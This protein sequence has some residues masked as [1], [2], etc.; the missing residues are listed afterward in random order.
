MRE[1]YFKVEVGDVF[2]QGAVDGAFG[3]EVHPVEKS[4]GLGM[5]GAAH[6][7]RRMADVTRSVVFKLEKQRRYGFISDRKALCNL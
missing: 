6:I 3:G 4:I 2:V 7:K 1:A 5:E